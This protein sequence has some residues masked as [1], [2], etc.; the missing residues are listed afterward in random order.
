MNAMNTMK[1][2]FVVLL[3]L[4]VLALP[5]CA[6]AEV[7]VTS[8]TLD[9]SVTINKAANTFIMRKD[10]AYALYDAHFNKLSADYA[11]MNPRNGGMQIE[12]NGAGMLDAQGKLIVPDVYD[13]VKVVVPTYT[14]ER[15]ENN[16]WVLGIHFEL[17]SDTNGDY[18]NSKGDQFNVTAVDVYF[19]DA[20]VATLNRAEYVNSTLYA[21]G[22]YLV[23]RETSQKGFY[24]SSTGERVNYEGDVFISNEY[25]EI[26]KK[27]VLHNATQQYAF[28]PECTL[29]KDDV[30]QYV[31]YNDN[32]D[33]L[34]LQ[35]NVI[36]QGPSDYKEYDSARYYGGDYMIIRANGKS[37]LVDLQGREV[38][39]AQYD[40][41]GG[42]YSGNLFRMGY[43]ALL[44]DGALS[45][46]DKTGKVTASV[47]YSLAEND[48]KGFSNNAL[49]ACVKNMGAYIVITA[50]N[51]QLPEMYQDISTPR[52][53][54]RILS[55][56]KNDLWGAID[57][58]GNV[59]IPFI[60]RTALDITYD[61]TVAYGQDQER[62]YVVYYLTYV[63]EAP[64][65]APVVEEKPVAAPAAGAWICPGCAH[66]CTGKFC[67]ECGTA[68]PV[69]QVC[70]N[71]G[72]EPA[73]GASPKFCPECGTKF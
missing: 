56:K 29:T 58:E 1:R 6:T 35:G 25:Y 32:G 10:G 42:G 3:A 20:K 40:A 52:A 14:D 70:Q 73:A 17:T 71:C 7:L 16:Y 11:N 47:S 15:T 8:Q 4:V 55:V 5:L 27:G 28:V 46:V 37:G 21:H 53:E 66:E 60:H 31:W 13:D 57:L 33:F 24:L 59:V 50:T 63:E 44:K 49:F 36:S 18:Y 64:A 39:P 69:V 2:F 41:L 9:S 62:N 26:Y 67:S 68:K 61:G 19:R 12:V 30:L 45:F 38:V 48:Y 54:Q 22:R 43:Q 34:D 51:G 72:Y 65:P 23:V